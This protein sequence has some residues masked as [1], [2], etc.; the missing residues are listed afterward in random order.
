MVVEWSVKVPYDRE[1]LSL[2]LVATILI[3]NCLVITALSVNYLNAKKSLCCDA[4][5]FDYCILSYLNYRLFKHT[6][7]ARDFST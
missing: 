5:V 1:F 4:L 6:A 7:R 2:S 3:I